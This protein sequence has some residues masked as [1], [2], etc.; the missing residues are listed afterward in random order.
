MSREG[1]WNADSE[2][3]LL[4]WRA[5]WVALAETKKKEAG[6]LSKYG[7]LCKGPGTILPVLLVPF[8]ATNLGGAWPFLSGFK[9]ASLMLMGMCGC[10]S[11]FMKFEDGSK[12]AKV[13][14]AFFSSLVSQVDEI[15]AKNQNCRPNCHVTIRT[16][17]LQ[18]EFALAES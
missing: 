17:R 6:Q 1:S 3:L 13:C 8:E 15:L 14:S 9:T 7:L 2:D 12:S 10:V 5:E 18:H 11:S 4:K 16:F